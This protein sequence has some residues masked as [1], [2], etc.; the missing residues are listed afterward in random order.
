MSDLQDRN[1]LRM[2]GRTHSQCDFDNYSNSSLGK[3]FTTDGMDKERESGRGQA[4]MKLLRLSGPLHGS[5]SFVPR[6]SQKSY[7]SGDGGG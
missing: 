4:C 6:L 1:F 3:S 2:V 7:N 5:I